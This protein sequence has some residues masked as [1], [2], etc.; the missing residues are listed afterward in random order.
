MT[1]DVPMLTINF[2]IL[3]GRV[4]V[5]RKGSQTIWDQCIKSA[6]I[7][8]QLGTTNNLGTTTTYAGSVTCRIRPFQSETRLGPRTCDTTHLVWSTRRC[9]IRWVVIP[10]SVV[11]VTVP[12]RDEIFC[13]VRYEQCDFQ[14]WIFSLRIEFYWD[15]FKRDNTFYSNLQV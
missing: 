12:I 11:S 3:H 9:V 10:Q 6:P 4:F 1:H 2:L 13:I 8:H 14:I 5:C 15:F 7:I